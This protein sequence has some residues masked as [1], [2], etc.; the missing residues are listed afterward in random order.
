MT[1]SFCKPSSLSTS[2]PT[3]TSLSS[4]SLSAGIVVSHEYNLT[5][6]TLCAAV[7]VGLKIETIISVPSKLLENEVATWGNWLFVHQSTAN[8]GKVKLV[9]KKTWN[10]VEPPFPEVLKQLLKVMSYQRHGLTLRTILMMLIHSQL[11][12]LCMKY[13][14][15]MRTY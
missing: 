2:K 6:H 3:I 12:N 7:S 8:Y 14:V 1:V 5:P 11:A 13:E 9:L 15:V 4:Q 10:F